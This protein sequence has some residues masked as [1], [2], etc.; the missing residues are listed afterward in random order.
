MVELLL[1]FGADPNKKNAGGFGPIQSSWQFWGPTHAADRMTQRDESRRLAALADERRTV[2]MLVMLLA[3]GADA[4]TLSPENRKCVLMEAVKRGPVQAVC[5]LLQYGAD[6]SLPDINRVSPLTVAQ[7]QVSADRVNAALLGPERAKWRRVNPERKEILRIL[8]S[9]PSLQKEQRDDEF[10]GTWDTW[11]KRV[12]EVDK[13]LRAVPRDLRESASAQRVAEDAA[14]D[15][16]HRQL[17]T[18]QK[19]RAFGTPFWAYD[20]VR[21]TLCCGPY[22]KR[23]RDER[24]AMSARFDE[25]TTVLTK[26]HA[27]A[28]PQLDKRRASGDYTRGKGLPA[29]RGASALLPLAVPLDKYLLRE[30]TARDA[31]FLEVRD[32]STPEEQ[33][34]QEAL[35]RQRERL[36]AKRADD[37]HRARQKALEEAKATKEAERSSLMAEV[38][39]PASCV[40][41][42]HVSM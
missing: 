5:A 14:L 33:A 17:A 40:L 13:K 19:V 6:E 18:S 30:A 9:W 29:A 1:E 28:P 8:K 4:N 20:P 11:L 7:D 36:L 21:R 22:T 41:P 42:R 25:G 31:G 10:F 24:A 15:V 16:C 35:N 37:R 23:E 12:E 3:S 34:R 39:C 38:R 2:D 32:K 26:A 27:A